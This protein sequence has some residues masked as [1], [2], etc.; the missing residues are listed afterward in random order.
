MRQLLSLG[1]LAIAAAIAIACGAPW[2]Y[3]LSVSRDR[4]RSAA[5][6]C[7]LTTGVKVAVVGDTDRDDRFASG[8]RLAWEELDASQDPL[9]RRIHLQFVPEQ[10]V[11]EREVSSRLAKRRNLVAVLGHETSTSALAAEVH[12]CTEGILFITP[13]AT[14]P[15]LTTHGFHTVFRLTPDD[16]VLVSALMRFAEKTH[17]KRLGVVYSRT[18][19]GESFGSLAIATAPDHGLEV[20]FSKSYL[21]Q[22]QRSEPQDF[23]LLAAEV[24]DYGLDALVVV[25]GL[26]RAAKLVRDLRSMGFDKP[27][28]GS[29]ALEGPDL[30]RVAGELSN[31]VYVVSVSMPECRTAAFLGFCERY[32]KRFGQDADY[33]ASQGYE[34]F[35]LLTDAYRVSK[36]A[37][38]VA[39]STTLR[40]RPRWSGLGGDYSFSLQGDA[41]GRPVFVKRMLHG[42]FRLSGATEGGSA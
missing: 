7:L 14:L 42:S 11:G 13:T 40:C 24:R 30:Y 16:R 10:A 6:D 25:D 38:P 8:V 36:T 2:G 27:I 20:V 32:K 34:S 18:L 17:L 5:G 28:L 22:Q 1:L 39:V 33:A 19:H 26:P 29:D 37:D 15:R 31:D 41:V 35:T 3:G 21:P 23:R 4:L 9:A 12:Y